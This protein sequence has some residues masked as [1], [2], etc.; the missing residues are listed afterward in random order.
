MLQTSS[1]KLIYNV[2]CN[3][4][5][6]ASIKFIVCI[7]IW[8]TCYLDGPINMICFQKY[9][10]IPNH[11]QWYFQYKF[12]RTSSTTWLFGKNLLVLLWISIFDI[13]NLMV[14]I[15]DLDDQTSQAKNKFIHIKKLLVY[16]IIFFNQ[17]WTFQ[18]SYYRVS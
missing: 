5:V 15:F 2:T 10:S 6:D 8:F 3:H 11:N 14:H 4:L 12:L 1:C 17:H 9:R 13:N 7:L 16:C 18:L